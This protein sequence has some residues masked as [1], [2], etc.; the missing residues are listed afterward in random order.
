M[1][2]QLEKLNL[3]RLHKTLEYL[4]T[5]RG[6]K[7]ARFTVANLKRLV[8]ADSMMLETIGIDKLIEESLKN[9]TTQPDVDLR[10]LIP[11]EVGI[12]GSLTVEDLRSAYGEQ[13][14][15]HPG[16]GPSSRELEEAKRRNNQQ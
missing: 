5:Q 16:I 12:S 14:S 4:N 7:R 10:S 1:T 13:R 8:K 11:S 15:K 6:I 9:P 3:L 2:Q